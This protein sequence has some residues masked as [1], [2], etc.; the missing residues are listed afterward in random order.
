MKYRY[1]LLSLTIALCLSQFPSSQALAKSQPPISLAN[2]YHAGIDLSKYL[3]SEKYDGARAWWNGEALISRGGNTYHAPEWF[4]RDLP[5]ET[6]DGELW[7]ARGRFQQLMKTIR[8]TVP[9]DDAWREVR[10]LVFDAPHARG[11]FE[12]RQSYLRTLQMQQVSP[13]M[14]FVEQRRIENREQLQEWLHEVTRLGGEGLMLQ[15]ADWQY[16]PGRH[17]GLLKLK[18]HEDAEAVVISHRAGKGKYDGMMGSLLVEDASGLQFRIGTGFS[19]EERRNP[20]EP[21]QVI[22]FRFQG[23]TRSGKPRFARFLRVRLPE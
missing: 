6:L 19:D 7:I 3:V 12:Q 18:T 10:F 11:T 9:N 2:T 20:P 16:L 4:I 13:Y 21:G 22:T 17:N 1:R 23:R 5:K 15:R 8:D 14:Q